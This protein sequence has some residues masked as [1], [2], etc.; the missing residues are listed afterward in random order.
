MYKISS[1]PYICGSACM[2]DQN[3]WTPWPICLKG[4]ESWPQKSNIRKQ[5]DGETLKM[6]NLDCLKYLISTTLGFL[7]YRD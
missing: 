4:T 3:S 2:S 7:R 5:P 6:S 1:N